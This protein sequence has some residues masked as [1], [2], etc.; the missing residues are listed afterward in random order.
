SERGIPSASDAAVLS[1]RVAKLP[2]SASVVR[3]RETTRGRH[4]LKASQAPLGWVAGLV[5]STT[6][7]R[8]DAIARSYSGTLRKPSQRMLR[9]RRARARTR[10]SEE[11][12][13]GKECRARA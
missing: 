5:V 7:A 13:V 6:T 9:S 10:R 2:N 12:R 11:R 8:A 1:T 4:A 3:V